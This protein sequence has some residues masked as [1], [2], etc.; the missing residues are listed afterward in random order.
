MEIKDY[1][2]YCI[3][4]NG[5]VVNTTRKN[6]EL[7]AHVSKTT[8]YY[9][10]NLSSEGVY[11]AHHVHVLLARHYIANPENKPTVDH[12][13]GNP[14]DN[15]LENLRWADWEE[16]A[17]NRSSVNKKTGY[18]GVTPCGKKFCSKIRCRGIYEYLGIFSSPVDANKAYEERRKELQG[19]FYREP[20]IKTD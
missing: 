7:K 4:P 16:Q 13:N 14:L 20:L 10:L 9:R 3:Y 18:R 5:T 15:R 2:N 12:I 17:F 19:E 11:K 8:G 1:E 6:K